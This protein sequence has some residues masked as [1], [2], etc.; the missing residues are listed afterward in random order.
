MRK[1]IISYILLSVLFSFNTLAAKNYTDADRAEACK[2]LNDSARVEYKRMGI[3]PSVLTLKV[4]YD[5]KSDSMLLFYS[6]TMLR[7]ST[8]EDLRAS[9]ITRMKSDGLAAMK[10]MGFSGFNFYANGKSC[11]YDL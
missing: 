8:V 5:A 7:N 3:E 6:G 10:G 1:K 2:D 11:R 9:W 4:T